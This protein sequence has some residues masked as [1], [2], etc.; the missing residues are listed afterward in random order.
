MHS[1]LTVRLLVLLSL[2][3]LFAVRGEFVALRDASTRNRT[4]LCWAIKLSPTA[5]VTD[6]DCVRSYRKHQIAMIYGDI[7][8]APYV[9][10]RLGRKVASLR[11]QPACQHR[12]PSLVPVSASDGSNRTVLDQTVRNFIAS[13][14]LL[15]T[16]PTKTCRECQV[17]AI[18]RIL[19]CPATPDGSHRNST[20]SEEQA[21]AG[22]LGLAVPTKAPSNTV[23]GS[24]TA[25]QGTVGDAQLY[26]R[27]KTLNRSCKMLHYCGNKKK[28]AAARVASLVE[29]VPLKARIVLKRESR[30][31]WRGVQLL[32][33]EWVLRFYERRTKERLSK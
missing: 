32:P 30:W 4:L 20:C 7:T 12:V 21:T 8:P 25:K 5:Y 15:S 29:D 16:A 22:H 33:N 14:A 3:T 17:L 9:R 18:R 28:T 26:G 23:R 10:E 2:A 27:S 19:P 13:Y 11:Q 1:L 6:A 31:F 24:G